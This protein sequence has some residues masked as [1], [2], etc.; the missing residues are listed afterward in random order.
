MDTDKGVGYFYFFHNR[1]KGVADGKIN[2]ISGIG[3]G[4]QY[5]ATF[6]ELNVVLVATADNKRAIGLPLQAALDHL[7]PLFKK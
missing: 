7:I 2:F 5:M 4:G 1:S 6:P 3:A